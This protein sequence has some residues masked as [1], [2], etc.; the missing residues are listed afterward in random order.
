M[1]KDKVYNTAVGYVRNTTEAEEVLQDVF[2]SI[3]QSAK[4][5]KGNSL[6]STW[7]YRITVNKSLNQIKKRKRK[8]EK[9]ETLRNLEKIEWSHPG[10]LLENQEKAAILFATIENLSDNQKTA[11]ILSFIEK[12]PQQEVATIMKTSLKS[13]ESLLQRAKANLRKKLIL[14]YPEGKENK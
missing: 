13:V 14:L 9:E 3:F 11:F 1:Y 10:I 2:M 12:L 8:R 5:F 4:T 7:V 6:V